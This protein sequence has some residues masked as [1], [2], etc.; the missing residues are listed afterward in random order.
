MLEIGGR[1]PVLAAAV[2]MRFK[3][4]FLVA[5][6]MIHV[7]PLEKKIAAQQVVVPAASSHDGK[8]TYYI[9]F[10]MPVILY[11]LSFYLLYVSCSSSIPIPCYL[12]KN[13]RPSQSS[14]KEERASRLLLMVSSISKYTIDHPTERGS[15]A[16]YPPS[17]RATVKQGTRE[18]S[19]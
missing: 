11:H 16:K 14:K 13:L 6:Q 12:V 17:G 5:S 18:G 9:I 7:P 1:A 4:I 2:A 15:K 10:V 19:K 3:P 8:S